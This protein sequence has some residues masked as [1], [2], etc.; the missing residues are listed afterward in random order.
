M[1]AIRSFLAEIVDYAGLFPPA[2][3]DM[4]SAV[5]NYA[6]YLAGAD[7]DLL[8]RFVVPAT[9]LSELRAAFEKYVTG[10]G[11]AAG[12][13]R[14]SVL[15]G[16]DVSLTRDLVTALNRDNGQLVCDTVE[17]Q[18]RKDSDVAEAV[19]RFSRDFRLFFEI[20]SDRD[21]T[22]LLNTLARCSVG[23]KIRTGG[24]TESAFP[25]ARQIARFISTC[26]HLDVPFKATA[27]LHH[28]V[29]SSYPLT[30]EPASAC[31][32]M[33][34][35][36]NV[37]LAAAFIRHGMTESVAVELLQEESSDELTFNDSGVG[38]RDYSLTAD[39]LRASRAFAISFGSCSFTEPV[40]EARSL[41]LI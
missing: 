32:S 3:L 17:L 9:R 19:L 36:L 2:S 8:G 14:L 37:F 34:G 4:E 18:G 29:R 39:E 20:A 28:A 10:E 25:P 22:A 11:D 26:V 27:G 6:D 23:A 16:D 1:Q 30:Y 5:R 33:F 7:S 35:Y 40:G 13:W 31:G 15:A 38:W 24:V 12:P 21:P 41:G